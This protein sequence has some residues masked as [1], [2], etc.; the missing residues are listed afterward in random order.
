METFLLAIVV[1]SALILMGLCLAIYLYSRGAIGGGPQISP[2]S[3][4]VED[5]SLPIET[6]EKIAG[7]ERDEAWN[8]IRIGL[9]LA[10]GLIAVLAVLVLHAIVS[11]FH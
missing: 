1:I 6:E 8:P 2:Q 10:I 4:S 3:E 11:A 9:V 5:T 7:R